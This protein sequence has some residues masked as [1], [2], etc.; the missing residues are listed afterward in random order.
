MKRYFFVVTLLFVF[1]NAA[2]KITKG[3]V[4]RLVVKALNTPFVAK[5]YGTGK[6][7]SKE[8]TIAFSPNCPTGIVFVYHM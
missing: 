7:V 5:N 6:D 8:L 3:S 2:K 4:I 1:A